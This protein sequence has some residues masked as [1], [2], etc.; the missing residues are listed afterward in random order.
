MEH[1]F[2]DVFDWP[3]HAMGRG[4]LWFL[5]PIKPARY[6]YR[7]DSMGLLEWKVWA[8]EE[9]AIQHLRQIKLLLPVE[10]RGFT[11]D[12]I[13]EYAE[14]NPIT[15]LM[16]R[17]RATMFKDSGEG[18]TAAVDFKT[19][20][21]DAYIK[22]RRDAVD[23]HHQSMLAVLMDSASPNDLA[24]KPLAVQASTI[25]RFIITTQ[26]PHRMLRR[27]LP[28]YLQEQEIARRGLSESGRFLPLL[29]AARDAGNDGGFE[30][31]QAAFPHTCNGTEFAEFV[32]LLAVR[33]KFYSEVTPT[34]C[35]AL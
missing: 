3:E 28:Y 17:I 21:C 35:T 32:K 14:S 22:E 23:G 16:D 9:E 15:S 10:D 4:L 11:Q 19:M 6:L 34:I 1:I 8:S 29:I 30:E 5:K 7:A 26:P 18:M 25:T 27:Y 13:I 20:C 31:L 33:A 2:L 12:D 24:N